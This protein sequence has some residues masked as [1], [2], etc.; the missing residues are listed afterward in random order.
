VLDSTT[1]RE[2]HFGRAARYGNDIHQPVDSARVRE[3]AALL[4]D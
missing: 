2:F 3:L 1:I 4:G